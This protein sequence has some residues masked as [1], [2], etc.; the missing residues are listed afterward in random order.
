ML[1]DGRNTACPTAVVCVMRTTNIRTILAVIFASS[2]K[3]V[4]ENVAFR[5]QD[6]LYKP[7]GDGLPV[8]G[9]LSPFLAARYYQKWL[10]QMK[11]K[12]K[13]EMKKLTEYLVYVDD[14]FGV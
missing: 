8:G 5:F 4:S 14:G 2:M 6:K 7:G 10:G 1:K 9:T 11:R 3:C 12:C 13:E